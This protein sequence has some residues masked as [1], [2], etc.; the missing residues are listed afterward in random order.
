[1]S[2]P[3]PD[4][5]KILACK[6]TFSENRLSMESKFL[7]FNPFPNEPWSKVRHLLTT[8]PILFT[9]FPNDKLCLEAWSVVYRI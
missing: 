4:F 1:M 9:Q 5:I 6:T 8:V 7:A 3:F 2:P